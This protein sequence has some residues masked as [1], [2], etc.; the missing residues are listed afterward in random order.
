MPRTLTLVYHRILPTQAKDR[1]ALSSNV[2]TQHLRQLTRFEQATGI[3]TRITFDDGCQGFAD[4]AWP[5]LKACRRE[6]M[7]FILPGLVGQAAT[8]IENNPFPLLNWGTLKVLVDDGLRIGSHLMGHTHMKRLSLKALRYEA[9][10]SRTILQAQLGIEVQ[11]VA[12]PYGYCSPDQAHALLDVGYNRV[13]LVYGPWFNPADYPEEV[14]PRM[15]MRGDR[16]FEHCL[17]LNQFATL[18]IGP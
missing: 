11:E 12:V 18:D 14:I 9:D 8:W 3:S 4:T 13:H 17:N 5:L 2:F 1:F 10:R 7:Q 16:R 15:E 6:A